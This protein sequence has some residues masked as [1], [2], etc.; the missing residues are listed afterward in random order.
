MLDS[1]D[2]LSVGDALGWEFPIMRRSLHDVRTGELPAGPWRW[3]DDTE[4]AC[5]VVAELGRHDRIDQD[6]LAAAFA[7]R[8]DPARDYGFLAIATLRRIS[9]GVPW[10]TAAGAAYDQQGSCGNGAAMRVAP[11]GAYYAGD[12]ERIVAEA[13]RSAEVTHLHREGI[14]GAVAVALAAGL[15]A[16]A[17]SAG[18]RP[19][20]TEFITAVLDRMDRGETTDLIA[21]ARTLLG[22]PVTV[23]AAELGNGSQVTAQNTVPFT[24]WVAATHLADYPSAITT[25]LAAD[26]DI[27]T[28]G[29]IAGGIVAA[30]TG[31]G[32]RDAAIVGVPQAWLAAREALPGWFD[33]TRAARRRGG[34]LRSWFA[35]T[36]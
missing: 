4:M 11:L 26:G 33:L 29:A 32:N 27:D 36:S 14:H 18:T 3:S 19:A 1:L 22:A 8:L 17:R 30:Y 10:R 28:T 35:R 15:A 12:P 2:G 25:C 34:R 24:L 31:V 7:R 5:T 6:R 20:P 16:Q 21:H 9:E 13:I 23:A